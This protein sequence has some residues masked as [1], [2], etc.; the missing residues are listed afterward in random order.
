M[1]QIQWKLRHH[2]EPIHQTKNTDQNNE[3]PTPIKN[4]KTVNSKHKNQRV[5][6][7]V[8]LDTTN[9]KYEYIHSGSYTVFNSIPQDR[10][11]SYIEYSI[12]N[13]RNSTLEIKNRSNKQRSRNTGIY[14][15]IK[16]GLN[17][18]TT[19]DPT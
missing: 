11:I 9:K 2:T 17:I 3:L 7:Y 6:K 4:Y 18:T 8:Q 1:T 10:S 19:Y 12:N 14:N 16:L 13:Y 15:G 5:I